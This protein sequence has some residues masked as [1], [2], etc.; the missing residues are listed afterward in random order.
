MAHYIVQPNDT[1][2]EI[3]L[4]FT[5]CPKCVRTLTEANRHKPT[6]V[7]PNG[8]VVFRD[9]TVGESLQIPPSW[10]DGTYKNVDK[11]LWPWPPGWDENWQQYHRKGPR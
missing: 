6:I 7:Y 2:I 11:D 9:L 1:S 5:G 8:F 10:L 4:K 3:T